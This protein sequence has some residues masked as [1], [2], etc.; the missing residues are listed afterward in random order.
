MARL[1]ALGGLLGA[2]LGLQTAC[3]HLSVVD[4][5]GQAGPP[6]IEHWEGLRNIH[7]RSEYH[8]SAADLGNQVCIVDYETKPVS[9]TFAN[10]LSALAGA[11]GGYLG[12][13]GL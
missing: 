8:P 6:R 7:Y 10:L 13:L 4:P 11:I 1:L 5:C 9:P 2:L 12:G 3:T